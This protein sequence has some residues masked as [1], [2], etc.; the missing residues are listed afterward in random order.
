MLL[1]DK[2]IIMNQTEWFLEKFREWEKS[3]GRKQTVTSFSRHLGVKQVTLTRWMNGDNEPAG[4]HVHLLA[5]KLGADI[6]AI[7]KIDPLI[8]H[9]PAIIFHT[10]RKYSPEEMAG[11]SSHSNI[12]W[13]I[14]T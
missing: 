10:D 2:I 14:T 1:P 4:D 12:S 3:T 9:G 13:A 7:L 6:Y 11:I 5:E 8:T